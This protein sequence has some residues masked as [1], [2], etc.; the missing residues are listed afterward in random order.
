MSSEPRGESNARQPRAVPARHAF[1]WY[2]EAMRLWKRGPATF[3]GLAFVTLALTILLEP[4]PVAG[5]VASNLVAP[6]VATGLLYASLAADRGDA[7]LMRHAIA[8]FSA[9]PGAQAAVILSGLA[10]FAAEAWTA[11]ALRGINLLLP[12]ANAA[13]LPLRVIAAIYAA[14]VLASLPLTFV[15]FAALFEGKGIRDACA[16]SMRAFVRNVAPL[17]LYAA[18]S[19]A[20]LF[21][22]LA[23]FGVGLILV[24]PWIASASYAAWKDIFALDASRR[25]E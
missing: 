4:V 19:F 16:V 9:G 1:A 23:T 3:A 6:L 7:P 15:P 2:S 13:D 25:T 5:F 24:L 11:W 18:M 21:L 17:L 8:A 14:G 20:L 10:A 12:T 22:A